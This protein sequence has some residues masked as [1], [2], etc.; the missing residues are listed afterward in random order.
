MYPW[1]A[2]LWAFWMATLARQGLQARGGRPFWAR[3]WLMRACW[4]EPVAGGG[5][6]GR[7]GRAGAGA[8]ATC[9]AGAAGVGVATGGRT[10]RRRRRFQ[11]IG[12]PSEEANVT[13]T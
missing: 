7:G 5:R 8:G 9:G 2:I 1:A 12:E 4:V 3:S 6:V 13:A 11:S 10:G